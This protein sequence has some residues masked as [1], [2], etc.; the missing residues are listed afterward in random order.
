MYSTILEIIN[1]IK[2]EVEDEY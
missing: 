1:N 2:G